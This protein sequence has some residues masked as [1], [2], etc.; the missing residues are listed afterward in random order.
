MRAT[1]GSV[2]YGDAALSSAACIDA[3][4]RLGEVDQWRHLPTH[5]RRVTMGDA[6]APRE[7]DPDRADVVVDSAHDQ[8]SRPL[9]M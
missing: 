9:W 5:G 2:R 1:R 8:A 4:D 6:S 7:A 3:Y